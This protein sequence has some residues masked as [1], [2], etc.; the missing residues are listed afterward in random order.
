MCWSDNAV[1]LIDL[2]ENLIFRVFFRGPPTHLAHF[3]PFFP[4]FYVTFFKI[5]VLFAPQICESAKKINE[6]AHKSQFEVVL[7]SIRATTM[8]QI[9]RENSPNSAAFPKKIMLGWRLIDLGLRGGEIFGRKWCFSP[10]LA[11]IISLFS[12]MTIAG[13]A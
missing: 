4:G 2:R 12:N 8:H 9:E 10:F 3:F 13:G 5:N 11:K 1:F 7:S 6:Q